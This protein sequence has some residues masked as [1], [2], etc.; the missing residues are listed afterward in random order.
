MLNI[1]KT[2]NPERIEFEKVLRIYKA[3]LSRLECADET[4]SLG[5]YRDEDFTVDYNDEAYPV[6]L[7]EQ[8]IKL[9]RKDNDYEDVLVVIENIKTQEN[10]LSNA[11]YD[12]LSFG[13][14]DRAGLL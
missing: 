3:T 5:E 11:S 7:T 14:L 12:H 1:F 2:K 6:R 4:N 13:E 8:E 9:L 10:M